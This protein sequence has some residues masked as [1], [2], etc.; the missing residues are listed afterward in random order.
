[1][2]C[3]VCD[4][5]IESPL[6]ESQTATAI[7]SL[8]QLT[9]GKTVV[10]LCAVCGHA[11]SNEL[12]NVEAFY[13]NSYNISIGSA[14]EDQVYEVVLG[15][16]IYRHDHQLSVLT[17]KIDVKSIQTVLDFGCAKARMMKLLKNKRDDIDIHLFDVS[18]NYKKYWND[19]TDEARQA[20]HETPPAWQS[21]F[22][23]VTS[24]FA[25]E[26]IPDPKAAIQHVAKLLAPGGTFY[27]VVPYVVSN[28]GDFIVIDHVNHF[29]VSSMRNLLISAGFGG[30]EIDT[31]AHRGALVITAVR[32]SQAGVRPVADADEKAAVQVIASY[33]RSS[34]A[35]I[36][37]KEARLG[38][39]PVAIYGAGFYGTYILSVLQDQSRVQYVVDKSPYLQG[40]RIGQVPIIAPRDLSNEVSAVYVGLN[41]GIPEETRRSICR[42]LGEGLELVLLD[43]PAFQQVRD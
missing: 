2:Q 22:D 18:N 41:P 40:K 37:A 32:R 13:E 15:Q 19:I 17:D 42:A 39:R 4:S 28:I 8:A 26:H 23:L 9:S 31:S 24:F 38:D 30:I 35:S 34:T 21:K 12:P 7:N 11:Q 43:A 27:C 1:M 16:L 29:T 5:V 36:A 3:V 33:W 10:W 14:D 20:V 6:Y 25:F